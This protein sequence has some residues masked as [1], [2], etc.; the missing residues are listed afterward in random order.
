[1]SSLLSKRK[2]QGLTKVKKITKLVLFLF[3]FPFNSI[4]GMGPAYIHP[5][6]SLSNEADDAPSYGGQVLSIDESGSGL[7]VSTFI[8]K[9]PENQK[10]AFESYAQII[11][12]NNSVYQAKL[13]AKQQFEYYVSGAEVKTIHAKNNGDIVVIYN[14][15]VQLEPAI[16]KVWSAYF[17]SKKKVWQ[18]TVFIDSFPSSNIRPSLPY[19]FIGKDDNFYFLSGY[20]SKGDIH[21]TLFV[22]NRKINTWQQVNESQIHTAST[23]TL[24]KKNYI[25]K[26]STGEGDQINR[27][28]F[29]DEISGLWSEEIELPAEYQRS[30][31]HSSIAVNDSGDMFWAK[32]E[33]QLEDNNNSTTLFMHQYNAV[34]AEWLLVVK[35]RYNLDIDRLRKVEISDPTFINSRAGE[36][37]VIYSLV[38]ET[39]I[40]Q[41][42]FDTAAFSQKTGWLEREELFRN[43]QAVKF[44]SPSFYQQ[45]FFAGNNNRATFLHCDDD[46]CDQL[47]AKMFSLESG[48]TDSF[49]I[50]NV[51]DTTAC[52]SDLSKGYINMVINN[53]GQFI[54][55]GRRG[56]LDDG[57]PNL[58]YLF[59]ITGDNSTIETNNS[60]VEL[61]ELKEEPLTPSEKK[62]TQLTSIDYSTLL[63]LLFFGIITVT[64][65][66]RKLF[67]AV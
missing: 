12:N 42:M 32:I 64:K 3:L 58:L 8:H 41:Y 45:F 61:K 49:A 27:I 18:S 24:D 66:I 37:A 48:W 19:A 54:I 23:I 50:P 10:S 55:A 38:Y 11:T 7:V 35:R 62:K 14:M 26:I 21:T 5:I 34:K 51:Y 40:L 53:N 36:T 22:Y 57:Q 15:S 31:Y 29:L 6:V 56:F 47:Y 28:S 30:Q 39:P 63:L 2:T 25:Q 1:M 60:C 43:L 44:L 33:S 13:I 16:T 9:N 65:K 52:G 59:S 46:Y 20:K 67:G 4:A 17:D